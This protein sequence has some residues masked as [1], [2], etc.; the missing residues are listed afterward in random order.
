MFL[1]DAK[2]ELQKTFDL[3]WRTVQKTAFASMFGLRKLCDP[4][5]IATK[6]DCFIAPGLQ[7]A[8]SRS[9][10]TMRCPG[11]NQVEEQP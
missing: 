4:A 9:P 1:N 8:H 6:D 5:R 2:Q 7:D 3:E 10:L 11:P